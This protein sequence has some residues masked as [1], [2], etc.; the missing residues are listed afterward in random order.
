MKTILTVTT[1]LL[2]AIWGDSAFAALGGSP[3]KFDAGDV[4]TMTA[5]SGY[6]IR[7]TV[8]KTGTEVREYVSEQGTVFAVTWHGPFKPNL[9]KLLGQQHFNTMVTHA[10]A[11]TK[12]GRGRLEVKSSG[13]VIRARGHM[14]AHQGQASL[15]AQF[16]AG[17][18]E[19]SI[20]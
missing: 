13:V 3:E 16:P 4:T 9:R 15:P 11:K 18:T 8:L 5:K 19:D 10:T 1:A 17:F 7:T 2:L 12:P 14:R 20:S 6:T